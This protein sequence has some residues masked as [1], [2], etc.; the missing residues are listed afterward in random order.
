MKEREFDLLQQAAHLLS[1]MYAHATEKQ[2]EIDCFHQAY[3]LAVEISNVL[4]DDNEAYPIFEM[5]SEEFMA[6]AKTRN[7]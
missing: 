1:G 4:D 5:S 2:L 3:D 7:D 6:F